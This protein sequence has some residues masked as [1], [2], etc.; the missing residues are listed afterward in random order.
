MKDCG[1]HFHFLSLFD[2]QQHVGDH[3]PYGQILYAG[4]DKRHDD[5]AE[6]EGGHLLADPAGTQAEGVLYHL[7]LTS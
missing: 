2:V 3:V 1:L 6:E 4:E 5:D 7:V